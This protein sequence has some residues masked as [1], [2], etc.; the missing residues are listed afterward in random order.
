VTL[1]PVLRA[2]DVQVPPAVAFTLFTDR[3]GAWWPLASHGVFGDESGGLAFE[4]GRLVERAVDGRRAA[5]GEVLRWDPPDAVAFTW[6]P[7]HQEGPAGRVEVRFRPVA[8]G[9]R[10]EVVH[11]GWE[12]F[13]DRAAA[14]RR[15]YTGP[16]AWGLVLDAFAALADGDPP[17]AAGQDPL[18]ELRAAYDAFFAEALAGGF[19]PAAAEEVV[20]HVLVNDDVMAGACRALLDGGGSPDAGD[21]RFENAV[22]NDVAV[23]RS[24]VARYGDVPALVRE[25]RS[26]SEVLL[27]LLARLVA[28][29]STAQVHARL[30]DGG[31]VMVDGS[32]PW[33]R[34]AVSVQATRHLPSHAGQLRA[35]RGPREGVPV[36]GGPGTGAP[37][38]P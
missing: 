5:W 14:V 38:I 19:G 1:P 15:A 28:E 30:V 32:V 3:I 26:R 9:T 12:S 34:L 29:G 22:S 27:A 23:L 8:G 16:K 25:G 10:V 33:L 2:A 18:D 17:G 35:L 20:A 11:E 36:G 31:A 4:D 6:H 13:G 37:R 21:V 24:T 7:G